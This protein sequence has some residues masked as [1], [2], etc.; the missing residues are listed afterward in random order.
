METKELIFLGFLTYLEVSLMSKAIDAA[1]E[2]E[3]KKGEQK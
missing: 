3:M 2:I 1:K